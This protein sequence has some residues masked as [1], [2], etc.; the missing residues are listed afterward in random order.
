MSDKNK[1]APEKETG[2]GIA[3][4]PAS[5]PS[6]VYTVKF[7]TQEGPGGKDDVIVHVGSTNDIGKNWRF[8]REHEVQ[9]PERAMRAIEDAKIIAYVMDEK[10]KRP[11]ARETSRFAYTILKVE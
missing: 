10:T 6:R 3:A 8:K 5:G 11:V 7:H 4:Q 1:T 9:I 2:S